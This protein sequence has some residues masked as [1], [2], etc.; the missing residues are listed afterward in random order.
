MVWACK[1]QGRVF[2]VWID[3]QSLAVFSFITGG[4]GGRGCRSGWGSEGGGLITSKKALTEK[5]ASSG[6]KTGFSLPA[7]RVTGDENMRNRMHVCRHTHTHMHTHASI[8]LTHTSTHTSVS[9]YIAAH[10]FTRFSFFLFFNYLFIR[11]SVARCFRNM[12]EFT[13]TPATSTLAPSQRSNR[14][15]AWYIHYVFLEEVKI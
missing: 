8:I 4:G 7:D 14:L 5:A 3:R 9:C 10:C 1:L 11:S 6:M 2:S 13:L 15:T 12:W